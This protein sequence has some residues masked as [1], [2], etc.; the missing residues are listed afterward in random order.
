MHLRFC[1]FY[2]PVDDI[3]VLITS[4]MTR[5]S[6]CILASSRTPDRDLNCF[7]LCEIFLSHIPVPAR[8]EKKR[9]AARRPHAGRT[10]ISD[11]IVM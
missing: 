3:T 8:G 7:S 6:L 4:A 11:V 1:L 5:A 9:T 10:S 2:G